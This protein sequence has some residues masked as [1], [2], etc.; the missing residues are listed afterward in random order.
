MN[1]KDFFSNE[2]KDNNYEG[3]SLSCI[4]RINQR[5]DNS[6]DNIFKF[7]QDIYF[8]YANQDIKDITSTLSF[9]EEFDANENQKLF[10]LVGNDFNS[11]KIYTFNIVGSIVYQNNMFNINSRFGDQFLQYMIA[12]SNGFL[13]LE[14][15]GG[16]SKD[17]SI[18]EWIFIYYFKI[19]LKEAF[20]L[21]VYKTYKTKSE[22]LT[23]I[24]GQI[25]INHYIKKEFF[26]GTTRCNYKEHSFSNEINYVICLALNKI[27]K[28]NSYLPIVKDIHTIKNAFNQ[29]EYKKQNIKS[30]VNHK[31]KNPF[32]SKYNE[33]FKMAHN[34]LNEDFG[35]TGEKEFSAFLFDIS[36]LFEHHIRSLLKTKF[37]L[38]IKNKRDF[39]IPNGCDYNYIYPDVVIENGD[40]TISI[41]DVKYKHFRGEVN[42]EDRFQLV[43]YVATYMNQYK[44]KECGFIY[45]SKSKNTCCPDKEQYLQVAGISIPFKIILYTI[46][47]EIITAENDKKFSKFKQDQKKYDQD[48]MGYFNHEI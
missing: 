45:P 27:F 31:V 24:R 3:L 17:I 16:Y 4:T 2:I 33:V 15:S 40:G 48:F 7:L 35:A 26:D 38:M 21:G 11:A 23:S 32:Y 22:D 8:E 9:G 20:G 12:S 30:L 10:Q 1:K 47:D 44:I 18:A 25:D 6:K 19:K 42:R 28:N 46:A 14:N 36:L 5:R 37:Q 29:I 34:I 39:K 13:E 41:Y 43:S